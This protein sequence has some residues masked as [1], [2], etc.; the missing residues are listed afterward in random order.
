M[1][2]IRH[3]MRMMAQNQKYS[4][5]TR[6]RIDKE[7]QHDINKTNRLVNTVSTIMGVADKAVSS[8]KAQAKTD[9]IAEKHGFTKE[10]IP[11]TTKSGREKLF[12]KD[13]AYTKFDSFG[14]EIKLS[15]EQINAVSESSIIHD[16]PFDQII[17]DKEGFVKQTYSGSNYFNPKDDIS[18]TVERYSGAFKDSSFEDFTGDL[19]AGGKI[20]TQE[21]KLWNYLKSGSL[22]MGES[23][24]EKFDEGTA[25]YD[26][27]KF[28]YGLS[29]Q[30]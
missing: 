13:I 10:T 14:N 15:S 26:F 27:V 30:K 22:Q 16:K 25:N 17:M 20:S 8:K 2:E 9:D 23:D 28:L 29:K 3:L 1:S 5:Q 6:A 21:A 12:A 4:E 24:L 7:L 18:K 11:Q 19:D